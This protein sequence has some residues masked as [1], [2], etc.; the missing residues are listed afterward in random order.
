[1]ED[2]FRGVGFFP[3]AGA[4]DGFEEELVL[5]EAEMLV[6]PDDLAAEF[7][8]EFAVVG[9]LVALVVEYVAVL[10][11]SLVEGSPYDV[12]YYKEK[13]EGVEGYKIIHVFIV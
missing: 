9:G 3:D 8:G 12:S 10:M 5:V 13:R 4:D 1:M 11:A 7:G 2:H 6:S